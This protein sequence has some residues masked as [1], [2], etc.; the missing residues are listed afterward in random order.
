M[1]RFGLLGFPLGHSFSPAYF[2]EKF[3]RE[4]IA[5][6]NYEIFELPDLHEFSYFLLK[7]SDLEGFNVTI[8]YKERILPYL[9]ELDESALE[10]GA[11]NCVRILRNAEKKHLLI[12][13]NTDVSAFEQTLMQNWELPRKALVFGTGGAA[14]AVVSVLKKLRIDYLQVSRS[15]QGDE[16][17]TYA[18]LNDNILIDRKLWIK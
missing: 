9:D 15:Q 5:D 16:I 8:P 2:Q 3:L 1:R 10:V 17:I 7:N 12:G 4:A 18:E 11:V 14:K 6:A 13:Y